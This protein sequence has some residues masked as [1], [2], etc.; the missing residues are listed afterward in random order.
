MPKALGKLFIYFL[1]F[2]KNK[3]QNPLFG[4]LEIQIYLFIYL[5]IFV[6]RI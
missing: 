4:E 5:F 6:V 3:K 1:F 2:L